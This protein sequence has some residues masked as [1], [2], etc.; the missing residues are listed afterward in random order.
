MLAK[1]CAISFAL[2][3]RSL[4]SFLDNL[5]AHLTTQLFLLADAVPPGLGELT[6]G[7]QA[8]LPDG[9]APLPDVDPAAVADA[10]A[11]EAA[12]NGGFFGFFADAFEA[13][14]K[15]RACVWV[16]LCGCVCAGGQ[17]EGEHGMAWVRCPLCL[18][19]PPA[20]GC[21]LLRLFGIT[22]LCLRARSARVGAGQRV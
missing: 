16:C 10:V 2:P 17:G 9:S 1:S 7:A 11:D 14:L 20:N 5:S 4:P 12:K 19:L 21:A 22:T 13:F 3:R 15:V 6:E 18:A 8:P